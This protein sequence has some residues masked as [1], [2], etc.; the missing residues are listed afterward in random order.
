MNTTIA[1]RIPLTALFL[2]SCL[3]ACGGPSDATPDMTPGPDSTPS[4]SA[5]RDGGVAMI[6]AGT[7]RDAGSESMTESCPEGYAGP[8]C[9]Q[10]AR[11]WQDGNADGVCS[12]ACDATGED[13]PSCGQ[14]TCFIDPAIDGRACRCDVGHIGDACDACDVGYADLDGDGICARTCQLECG[15]FGTCEIA[16]DDS[17][18]CACDEGYEGAAC[19]SCVPGYVAYRGRCI[20]DLPDEDGMALWLDADATGSLTLR[21]DQVIRWTDRRGGAEAPAASIALATLRPTFVDAAMNG[22]PVVRFDGVD[23]RLNVA[24][25]AGFGGDDYTVF[26]LVYPRSIGSAGIFEASHSEFGVAAALDLVH[27]GQIGRFVHRIPLTPAQQDAVEVQSLAPTQPTLIGVRRW[28]SGLLD[29]YRMWTEDGGD[30]MGLV[31]DDTLINAGNIGSL[32]LT[33]GTGLTD[34][35]LDGDVAEII[36]YERALD[37]DEAERVLL[38]LAAKWAVR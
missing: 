25:F 28:T 10:C 24:D 9:D 32:R 5:T 3:V 1:L 6:D 12:L 30:V 22:R 11:G 20:L 19:E 18:S 38:Y 37:D 27:P 36:V 33:I 16:T 35:T 13:A 31:A 4:P 21:N 23:D 17:E 7:V 26:A 8:R 2:A 29:H 34:A 14:G 15:D